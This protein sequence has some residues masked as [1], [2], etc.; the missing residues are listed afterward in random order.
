MIMV[1]CAAGVLFSGQAG[2]GE[3]NAVKLISGYQKWKKTNKE[4]VRIEPVFAV[5][6]AQ[7]N[8]NQG[9]LDKADP[10][11]NKYINVYVNET[12]YQEFISKKEPQFAE[13]TVIVKEKLASTN[14]APELLTAMVKRKAGFDGKNGDW[15]YFALDGKGRKVLSEGHTENCRECHEMQKGS[16]YVFRREL[17]PDIRRDMK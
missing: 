2:N 12:G 7:V 15:E 17:G 8:P 4:P 1:A 6:C 3:T 11:K 9:R 5:F 16:D 10:H 14:S 13:G